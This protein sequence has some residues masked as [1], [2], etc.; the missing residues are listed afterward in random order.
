IV[1]IMAPGIVC[2][3]PVRNGADVLPEW[4]DEA[5]R[6]ADAV[7]ALDDGST[8]T[9]GD[10]LRAHPLVAQV[11]VNRPR[12]GYL[13]WHDGVNRNRLLAAAAEMTPEWIVSVDIDERIDPSDAAAL[14]AFVATEARPSCAYGF[15]L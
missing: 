9:T 4:L 3:L 15:E 8:D 11:L 7:I 10:V 14:R 12:A 5:G 2:L 13:G 1:P 6:F